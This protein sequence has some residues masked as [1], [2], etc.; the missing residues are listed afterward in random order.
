MKN[1][2][3][4]NTISLNFN[5]Q[6]MSP[7]YGQPKKNMIKTNSQFDKRSFQSKSIKNSN[8]LLKQQSREDIQETDNEYDYSPQQVN[9]SH[10]VPP[11]LFQDIF[12]DDVSYPILNINNSKSNLQFINKSKNEINVNQ[13]STISEKLGSTR[14]INHSSFDSKYL[15][16]IKS[17][18]ESINHIALKDS[19]SK[20]RRAEI[21]RLCSTKEGLE[22]IKNMKRD[23]RK[24]NQTTMTSNNF[25]RGIQ[26]TQVNRDFEAST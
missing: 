17:V 22:Y 26:L 19:I 5:P 2:I 1:K 7:M 8:F 10:H 24:L 6:I 4:I 11:E 21:S 16:Q 12:Y 23:Q 14:N 13:L 25:Y 3:S 20:L 18:N 15:N 9:G